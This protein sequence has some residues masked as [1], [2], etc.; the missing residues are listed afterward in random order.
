MA[1][2]LNSLR[3]AI[4]LT[5]PD[6]G[7]LMLPPGRHNAADKFAWNLP[8]GV[9]RTDNIAEAIIETVAAPEAAVEAVAEKV[10]APDPVVNRYERF[11]K[12]AKPSK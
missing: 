5:S 7:S 3:I 10:V 9:Q 1:E 8:R 4:E 11:E 2:F 6:G 12:P